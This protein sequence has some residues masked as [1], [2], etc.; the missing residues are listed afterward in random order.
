MGSLWRTLYSL[1]AHI[2]ILPVL[3]TLVTWGMISGLRQMDRAAAAAPPL[4]VKN[5]RF[6]LYKIEPSEGKSCLRVVQNRY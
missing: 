3:C 4:P 6:T 5:N 2:P 1:C